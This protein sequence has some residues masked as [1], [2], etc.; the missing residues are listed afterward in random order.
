MIK[1]LNVNDFTVVES[2]IAKLHKLHVENRPDF[3]IENEHPI[4]KK[5]YKAMLNNQNK[6]NIA[7]IIDDEIV[8]VCFAT[9]K[10]RIEKSIYIDDIFVLEEFRHQGIATKL[11]KQVESIAK[12]IGAKRI[13]LTVWQ[14]NN[15][16]LKFYESL[17]METQRK[18]LETRLE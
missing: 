5:E 10:D 3:Y 11:Y 8:G 9:I 4:N 13:D 15:T 18:I 14:F 12:D 1:E 17:G 7:Y 6:I 2:I 16:A